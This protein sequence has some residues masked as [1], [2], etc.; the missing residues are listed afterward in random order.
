MTGSPLPALQDPRLHG[1]PWVRRLLWAG[2]VLA[3]VAA[4]VGVVLPGL[5]TTPFVLLAAACFVRASPRAHAW[6]LASRVFG[7]M[8]AEWEQHRRIP[9]RIKIL[10]VTMMIAMSALSVWLFAGKP[11]LQGLVV[12]AAAAGCLVVGRLPSR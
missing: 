3:L 7:P 2:G 6:L 12:A 4:A 11:W 5:P 10:A 9:R 8:L 1:S